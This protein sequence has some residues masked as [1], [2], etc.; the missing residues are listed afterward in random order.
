RDE[1]FDTSYESLLA[2]AATL[3]DVKPRSTPADVLRALPT[4][5]YKEWQ[6]PG[7]DLRCPICLD[8]YED[9]DELLKAEP[10]NHWCHQ[11]CLEVPWFYTLIYSY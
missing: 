3:G 8:D 6:S 1:D 10:C 11:G 9:A 4:G 5:L 7:C 2:L